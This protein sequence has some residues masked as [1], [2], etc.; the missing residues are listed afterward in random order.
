MMS[1]PFAAAAAISILALLAIAPI[2][3]QTPPAAAD[4]AVPAAQVPLPTE[5]WLHAGS[6][7]PADP[8]WRT[9]TLPN[10]LRY[11]V[12]RNATPPDTVA[13]RVRIDAG[14]LMERDSESGW[15][16]LLEHM[17]FR[18]TPSR[19]D[20]E[21]VKLWQRLGAT[22]GS[23]TNATTSLRATTYQLD[24][25]RNDVR[26]L[27][28][29]VGTLADMIRNASIDARLLDIERKVVMAERA[30]R[31]TPIV[32]K[33]QDAAKPLMLAGLLAAGQ[34]VGGT[35]ATLAGATADGLRAFHKR[36][37]RPERAVVVMVGDADPALLEDLVKRRFGDW[38][39]DGAAPAEPAYGAP[40]EPED[41]VAIVD[42]PLIPA[43]IQVGFV[44]PHDS[45]PYTAERQRA[46]YLDEVAL[47]V[48]N[49]RLANEAQK[50]GA[51]LAAGAGRSRGRNLADQVTLNVSPRGREWQA[52]LAEAYG[53]L[54]RTLATP[55]DDAEINQQIAS[56]GQALR[57]AAETS[58]TWSSAA[59]A[60]AF[61][62]DVDTGDVAAP[63]PYYAELFGAQTPAI[64][65]AAV[66]AALKTMFAPQPRLLMLAPEAIS[67]GDAAVAA[68]LAKARATDGGAAVA[69][70]TVTLDQLSPKL[71]PGSV[72]RERPIAEF[73]IDRVTFANGVELVMKR[74][75]FARDSIGVEVRIGHGL[76]GKAPGTV[77]PDW[78]AGIMPAS[79]LAD[80]TAPEIARLTAGRQIGFG[81]TPSTDAL[82]FATTTNPRDLADAM[83]LM[84]AGMTRPRFDPVALRRFRD[85]F[86]AS[87]RTIRAQPGSVFQTMAAP[88]LYGGDARFRRL[89]PPSE[90]VDATVDGL[91]AHWRRE[92][93]AGPIRVMVVGEYDRDAT[94]AA[95]A[96]SF[97]ALPSRPAASAPEAFQAIAAPDTARPLVLTHAGDANQAIVALAWRTQG[98]TV[99]LKAAR[100]MA[101]A[102]AIIQTRLTDEF[103]GTDGGSYSPFV[104]VIDLRG[105]EG[106]GA[107]MAGAQLTP[108]RIDGFVATLNRIVGD[109][110]ANGPSEDALLRAK[111]TA[112]GGAQRALAGNAYWMANLG[113]ELDDPRQLESI[114]TF[115]SGRRAVDAAAVQAVVRRYLVD[116]RP[117]RIEVRPEKPSSAPADAG[118]RD[119]STTK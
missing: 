19:P 21:A 9:G 68:A 1:R 69:L 85:G 72:A 103:R 66:Q 11:A 24:L 3:A 12:R 7:I 49:Q 82:L 105:F 27:D 76:A 30:A 91:A 64:T 48:L 100:A 50:G 102:S 67:G 56:L 114:R 101:V 8:A 37:Y 17:I 109:I 97:G 10:G 54:N 73:D 43:S 89:P 75:G 44:S 35:D 115:V 5:S 32:R 81:L 28:D 104:N 65:P 98:A 94:I 60:N 57:R 45:S 117:L 42:D 13:I 31:I 22:F 106:F 14:A 47:R 86:V 29:A 62:T 110:A 70:R 92:L 6:D 26:S 2:S 40:T 39:A 51:M 52:A 71:A 112:I 23:D 46:D 113:R 53:V 93:A 33:V 90:V 74:T 63:R 38:R 15:A 95:V 25:P 78:S 96:A 116:A 41:R 61:V 58:A 77:T 118:A 18:G 108:D 84:V 99:D 80:F 59:Y 36:W 107:M 16:H 79:G 20:G 88:A 111:E 119:Q 83:R 55:I 34:D 4:T 87:Y